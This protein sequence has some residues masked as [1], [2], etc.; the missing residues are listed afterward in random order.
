VIIN[1]IRYTSELKIYL[2]NKKYPKI[3]H[4]GPLAVDNNIYRQAVI[5]IE[6]YAIKND[7]PYKRRG[8]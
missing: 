8:K 3:Y 5:E 7:I 2:Y 1:N 6:N 4:I